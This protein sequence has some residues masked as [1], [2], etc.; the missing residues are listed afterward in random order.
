MTTGRPKKGEI[1]NNLDFSDAADNTLDIPKKLK[2]YLADNGLAFRWINKKEFEKNG[3]FHPKSWKPAPLP[4][5]A[6]VANLTNQAG[7][8][9]RGDSVLAVKPLEMVAAQKEKT[10]RKRD[11]YKNI[12]AK[13]ATELRNSFSK[14]GVDA[15]VSV[16]Y[17]DNE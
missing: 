14:Q 13:K 6:G 7:F 15:Q 2:S 11:A 9:V 17:E 8:L 3:N 4:K 5:E 12:N 1:W 16:G 10:R